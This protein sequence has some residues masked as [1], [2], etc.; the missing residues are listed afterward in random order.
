LTRPSTSRLLELINKR[1]VF[2]DGAMGTLISESHMALAVPDLASLLF[3]NSIL[4]LH[5]DYLSCGSDIICTNTFNANDLTKKYYGYPE[6]PKDIIRC[7]AQLAQEAK[8]YFNKKN[9]VLKWVAGCI[10]P[11]P[12]ALSEKI[13]LSN[14]AILLEAKKSFYQQITSL[15]HQNVDLL[16]FETFYDPTN[17]LCAIEAIEQYQTQ[18]KEPLP[19]IFSFS[20]NPNLD[21]QQLT[22]KLKE[23]TDPLHKITTLGLGIN[24]CLGIHKLEN[25][26][27]YIVQNFPNQLI[28]CHPNLSNPTSEYLDKFTHIINKYKISIAGG[29]CGTNP[30]I[31]KQL[32]ERLSH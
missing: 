13:Y 30:N 1:V 31:I 3:P 29:C 32:K 16:L 21:N 22:T 9:K 26:L 14:T 18:F 2:F 19:I 17:T 15:H 6:Q 28:S 11:L 5:L 24:C 7:S 10:G 8:L 27:A 25:I 23:L 20:V 4:D 12:Q